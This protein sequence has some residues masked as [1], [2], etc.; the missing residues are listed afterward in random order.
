MVKTGRIM[1]KASRRRG[2]FS[3]ERPFFNQDSSNPGDSPRCE[4]K[5][6]FSLLQERGAAHGREEGS[7]GRP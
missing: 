5:A 3:S 2:A 4:V 6:G 1:P 7:G